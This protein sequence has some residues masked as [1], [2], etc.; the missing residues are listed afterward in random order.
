MKVSSVSSSE[1][2][3]DVKFEMDSNQKGY[4]ELVIGTETTEIVKDLCKSEQIQFYFYVCLHFSL[5]L[6]PT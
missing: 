1:S 5:N 2:H 4:T 6:A 3:F